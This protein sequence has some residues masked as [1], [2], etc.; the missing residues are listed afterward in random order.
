MTYRCPYGD[1]I[2]Y[3][4]IPEPTIITGHLDG[5]TFRAPA[6]SHIA[7]HDVV[8][9]AVDFSDREYSLL[10]S[11]SSRFERC[12][13]DRIR[14]ENGPLGQYPQSLFRECT[15][16][17]AQF[18]IGQPGHARF[19]RCN[20]DGATIEDW[21]TYCAEFVECTFARARI[22]GRFFGTPFECFGWLQFRHRRKRNEFYGNDFSEADLIDA[23]F[24]DGIDLDAQRLPTSREYVRIKDAL[25][26][27]D[28]ARIRIAV[29]DDPAARRDA[30]SVLDMLELSA[31]N[32]RDL[33]VRKDVYELAPELG[34]EL[35]D[36]LAAQPGAHKA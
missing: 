11:R 10:T 21:F 3:Y 33:F 30:E 24:N 9:Q 6:S 26:R 31:R 18:R 5:G 2:A 28:D 1:P 13:F 34:E 12:N 7:F 22:T 16:R 25:R 32:Q 36:L 14:V 15:F 20:F 8:A 35:W 4:E 29:W 27:I 19:E 17:D 23:G